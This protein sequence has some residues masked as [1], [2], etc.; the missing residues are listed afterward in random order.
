MKKYFMKTYIQEDELDMILTAIDA[1]G[2][3][4]QGSARDVTRNSILGKL[5]RNRMVDVPV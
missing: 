1:L 5:T 3:M 2:P 4:D